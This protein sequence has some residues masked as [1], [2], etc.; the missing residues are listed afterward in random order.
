MIN[1]NELRINNYV[2]T[3]YDELGYIKINEILDSVVNSDKTKGISYSSLNPIKLTE[4]ILLKCG[5]KFKKGYF[6]Y[7]MFNIVN[8][9]NVFYCNSNGIYISNLHQLQN[10]YFALTGEELTITL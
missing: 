9:D 7:E 5:F 2:K 8:I 3:V 4:E 10:L 1:K 6:I